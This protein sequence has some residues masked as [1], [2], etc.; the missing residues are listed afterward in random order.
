MSA[1]LQVVTFDD[2]ATADKW[3]FFWGYV[4]RTLVAAI[5]SG[6]AGGIVGGILGFLLSFVTGFLGTSK[7][8]TLQLIR[9]VGG[10]AG[11]VLGF[12]VLWHLIRWLFAAPWFGYR[13][14]LVRDAV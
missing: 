13:L 6:I 8:D 11:L 14:R 3:R 2:L 1:T 7:E 9:L 4:W 12:V 5:A 10:T